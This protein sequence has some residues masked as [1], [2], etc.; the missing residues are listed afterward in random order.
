MRFIAEVAETEWHLKFEHYLPFSF[1]VKPKN[2]KAVPNKI[3]SV[4]Y[5]KDFW[6][7]DVNSSWIMFKILKRIVHTQDSCTCK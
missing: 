6:F 4:K 5:W 3:N 2:V 1:T 7:L